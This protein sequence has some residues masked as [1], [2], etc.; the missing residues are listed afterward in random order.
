MRQDIDHICR[1]CEKLYT[2]PELGK[3]EEGLN[4]MYILLFDGLVQDCSNSS[5]LAVEYF[6]SVQYC[7]SNWG[8]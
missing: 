1:I 8:L 4:I 6:F 3:G 2:S 5:A 7:K